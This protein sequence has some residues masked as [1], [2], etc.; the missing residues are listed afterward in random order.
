MQITDAFPAGV[1]V[2]VV[3]TMVESMVDRSLEFAKA[4]VAVDPEETTTR[5]AFLEVWPEH[6]AAFDAN[7]RQSIGRM[8]FEPDQVDEASKAIRAD[9]LARREWRQMVRNGISS[10]NPSKPQHRYHLL[11]EEEHEAKALAASW[12]PVGKEGE[13]F[14]VPGL[15]DSK[16]L[17]FLEE[18]GLYDPKTSTTQLG[19]YSVMIP[20]GAG[21]PPVKMT[22]RFT[23]ED[24]LR[25]I[26][27]RN[28]MQ[29]NSDWEQQ[30]KERFRVEPTD[31]EEARAAEEEAG[32][33]F[34]EE[35]ANDD[36][37]RTRIRRAKAEVTRKNSEGVIPDDEVE[38]RKAEA[39]EAVV[40]EYSQSLFDEGVRLFK[41]TAALQER[42]AQEAE[43]A[44]K[45]RFDA[46]NSLSRK[47]ITVKPDWYLGKE[48]EVPMSV[49]KK[50]YAIAAE[51]DFDKYPARRAWGLARL[52]L[53]TRS[54]GW[55]TRRRSCS[56]IARPP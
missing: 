52:D 16:T 38:D 19:T 17:E 48:A 45:R 39:E 51:G 8:G 40:Q 7:L 54:G 21:Q 4:K 11:S 14:G 42:A 41:E 15:F 22:R 25:A 49:L 35:N 1:G 3:E 56:R 30:V 27:I 53:S 46:E 9:E 33:K 24:A 34:W 13:T 6:A 43:R 31:E 18:A 29:P 37:L 47:Q 36:T 44:R 10:S 28:Q 2:A 12:D 20:G 26:W 55:R 32:I 50:L 5:E 23:A